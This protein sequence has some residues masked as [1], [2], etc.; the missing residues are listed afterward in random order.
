MS[1][2]FWNRLM[3]A[4][5]SQSAHGWMM[6]TPPLVWLVMPMHAAL[7]DATCF[8]QDA[9]GIPS[10]MNYGQTACGGR[11]GKLLKWL[12]DEAPYK[13]RK[14]KA[15]WR[16]TRCVPCRFIQLSFGFL[17]CI[18]EPGEGTLY[19]NCQPFKMGQNWMFKIVYSWPIF[20][21]T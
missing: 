10:S 12:A 5:A 17:F 16:R 19:V 15:W 9:N 7:Q 2:C 4:G 13:G 21:F 11:V 20:I 6:L 8:V 14:K 1:S 18:T 3:K